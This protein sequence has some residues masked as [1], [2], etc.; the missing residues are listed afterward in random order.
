ME[1]FFSTCGVCRYCRAGKLSVCTQRRS[2]GTHVDGGFA[3]RL[4]VPVTNLHRIPERLDAHAAAMAE[5]L[6]YLGTR[7]RGQRA[8]RANAPLGQDFELAIVGDPALATTRLMRA[9][10]M[11][12]TAADF[13]LGLG[14]WGLGLFFLDNRHGGA[15]GIGLDRP[16]RAG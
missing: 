15:V 4:L 3:P 16:H 6:E 5:P 9:A 7:Q 12:P 10:W 14:T 11:M 1:T 13:G 8:K 2:I